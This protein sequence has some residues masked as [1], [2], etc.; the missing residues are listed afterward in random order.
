MLRGKLTR[1]L[2]EFQPGQFQATL[3]QAADDMADQA[4]LDA[5]WF[6]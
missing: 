2:N 3:L 1:H 4:A 6:N 5:I